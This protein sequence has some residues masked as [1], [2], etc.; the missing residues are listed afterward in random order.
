[1]PTS[2][3]ALAT[4]SCHGKTSRKLVVPDRSMSAQAKADAIWT[5][6]RVMFSRRVSIRPLAASKGWSLG[7]PRRT[8]AEVV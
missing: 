8:W 3:T 7:G 6:L 5:S 4:S 1:M 2:V